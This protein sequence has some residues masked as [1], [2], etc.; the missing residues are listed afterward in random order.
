[1]P[2]RPDGVPA[3]GLYLN[4]CDMAKPP[5]TFTFYIAASIDKVWEGFVSAEAKRTIFMGADFDVD[6]RPGP[7]RP[8]SRIDR[9][10]TSTSDNGT[11]SRCFS[12]L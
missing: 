2:Y 1:M 8:S 9:P 4:R 7:E 6:L 5:L 3:S 12:L 11:L 10:Q